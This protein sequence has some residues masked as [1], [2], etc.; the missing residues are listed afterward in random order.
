MARIGVGLSTMKTARWLV[1]L[2]L[3]WGCTFASVPPGF[4]QVQGDDG[5]AAIVVRGTGEMVAKPD[6]AQIRAGVVSEADTAMVALA[7]NSKKMAQMFAAL[8][9]LGVPEE[10]IQTSHFSISPQY[11]RP[12]PRVQEEPRIIGYQVVNQ[13][14]IRLR[15][16]DRL[17]EALDKLVRLGSNRIHGVQFSLSNPDPIL[18]QARIKAIQEARHKADLLTRSA[19][20]KLG[21]VLSIRENGAQMPRPVFA[22]SAEAAASVP[23]APGQE[24]LSVTVTMTFALD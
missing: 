13:V 6:M 12:A 4:T 9:A 7:D 2:T 23:I 1:I 19:G 22:R 18:D 14:T 15:N 8:K 16:L 21:R 20:V 24:T 11:S 10:D 17:G 5:T 3:W